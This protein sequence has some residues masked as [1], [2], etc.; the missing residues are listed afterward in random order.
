M[1]PGNGQKDEADLREE[2]KIRRLD[3][4]SLSKHEGS[5]GRSAPK[6]IRSL[7]PHPPKPRLV[8]RSK[9]ESST[10]FSKP[11]YFPNPKSLS[12]RIPVKCLR[13]Q[14][15]SPAKHVHIICHVYDPSP[16][17]VYCNRKEAKG[18]D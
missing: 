4:F 9:I 8:A 2:V 7:H 17:V 11:K 16:C 15:I 14:H 3:F 1:G 12:H 10:I 13:S 18:W 5:Y 6:K